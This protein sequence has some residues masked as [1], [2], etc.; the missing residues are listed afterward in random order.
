MWPW[1]VQLIRI[2]QFSDHQW[3]KHHPA[4]EPALDD[5]VVQQKLVTGGGDHLDI[6]LLAAEIERLRA[7]RC[8]I[9]LVG[10]FPLWCTLS[11]LYS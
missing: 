11:G 7:W 4:C 1:A 5:G 10:Q 2:V 6:V 9:D 8:G 3:V